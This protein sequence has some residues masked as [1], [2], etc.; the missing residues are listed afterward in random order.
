VK[1]TVLSC[2]K[3]NGQY[4]NVGDPIELEKEAGD[5]LKAA[6]LVKDFA[7]EDKE[8]VKKPVEKKPAP[9]YVPDDLTQIKGIGPDLA[10]TLNRLGIETF[11]QL[12]NTGV[13]TLAG[14]P[15]VSEK[16]ARAFIKAAKKKAK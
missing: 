13:N 8:A 2:I 14:I 3:N 1:Y 11:T 5:A 9:R 7:P 10:G 4:Y 12:S 16:K 6:G 15:N